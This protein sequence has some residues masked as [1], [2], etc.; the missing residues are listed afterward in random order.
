MSDLL[1]WDAAAEVRVVDERP[2]RE[3]AALL[4]PLLFLGPRI[5]SVLGEPEKSM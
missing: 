1:E 3:E 5:Q 2:V 4:L